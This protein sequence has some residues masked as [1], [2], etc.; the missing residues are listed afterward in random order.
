MGRQQMRTP[1]SPRDL[2][3]AA[4]V[5]GDAEPGGPG[6]DPPVPHHCSQKHLYSNAVSVN[7]DDS[8][9]SEPPQESEAKDSP[10]SGQ[11]A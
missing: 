10:V 1:T 4:F 3:R 5:N 9:N 8:Q 6:A 2:I 7:C 11:I